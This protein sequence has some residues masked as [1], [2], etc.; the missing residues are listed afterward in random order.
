M[1]RKYYIIGITDDAELEL[2][3]AVLKII[4]ES[5]VFSG[6]LRHHQ[7]VEK[8]LPLG[9][10]WIDITVPLDSV[11]DA[12]KE[13]Q[14]IVVFASGDPLFFGFA[15][16]VQRRD[17][18]A[19]IEVFPTF[20]SLQLLAHRSLLP[21]EGMRT[22]SL[23][24]RPW[25]RFEQALIEG[26]PLMGVLTDRN[27]TPNA[28]AQRM[29]DYGYNNYR[30]IVGENL[31]NALER[32]AEYSIEEVDQR[33]FSMPN[34]LILK[35]THPRHRPLGIPESDF[36]LLD[37]RAK[38]ITKMP[39]RLLS[40]AALD[41]RSHQTL[42]DVGFCTGSVS[43]EAKLQFPHLEIVSFEQ[44][45]TGRALMETNTRRFGTPGIT[46]VIGDFMEMDLAE[47]PRPDAVFIG[48]HGGQL[49]SMIQRIDC[50]L[51]EGGVV[52]FNSVST[53]SRE[54]FYEGAESC[55]W[56]IVSSQH[57]TLDEHNPITILKAVKP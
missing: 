25:K 26:E 40:L 36:A 45:E 44:R 22:L 18:E 23:T 27:K 6:G 51:T 16:T 56:H 41:L 43:I 2:S 49:V 35:L 47:Y 57:I 12:Y 13:H 19:I 39:I 17:P 32:V 50:Y 9:A 38:M 33:S 10:T 46:A 4:A 5:K 7:L 8:F 53:E 30:M 42:W 24:G 28:I 21:Y 20:N 54:A 52:V 14:E 48:G 29:L 11:F 55:K 31:G 15:G 34:C 1:A 37:G 3:S